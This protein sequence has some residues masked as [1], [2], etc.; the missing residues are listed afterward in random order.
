MLTRPVLSERRPRARSYE[1]GLGNTKLTYLMNT[2]PM[3]EKSYQ[4]RGESE[5]V[6]RFLS[7]MEQQKDISARKMEALRRNAEPC[8]Q[9]TPNKGRRKSCGATSLYDRGKEIIKEREGRLEQRR[10]E[11]ELERLEQCTFR[12]QTSRL[13]PTEISR[14]TPS[15]WCGGG[16]TS[17][18]RSTRYSDKNRYSRYE[19]FNA[20]DNEVREHTVSPITIDGDSM[21]GSID[22][23]NRI[24]EL[25]AIALTDRSLS[26]YP[27]SDRD[28]SEA[29]VIDFI[30]LADDDEP[31][32]RVHRGLSNKWITERHSRIPQ[33]KCVSELSDFLVD[34]A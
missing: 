8:Y 29:A 15:S 10:R 2:T 24:E 3:K 27:E 34:N 25:E 11:L 18:L 21:V 30:L 22:L 7:R 5:R 33:F 12:P 32:Q 1:D 28:Q 6:K 9:F 26:V 19:A 16:T 20:E 4:D 13:R 23:N 14:V 17:V 31:P